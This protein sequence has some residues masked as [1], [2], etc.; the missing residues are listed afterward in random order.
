MVRAIGIFSGGL[1]SILSVRLLMDQGFKPTLLAF[2]TPFFPPDK[3]LAGA[4]ALG[5][6]LTEV[7]IYEDLLPL[8]KDPPHGLG[9]NLNPCVDCHALMFRRAGEILK[10]SG[11]PGFLFSG[12]VLGQRPMSQN[13]RALK[14]VAADSGWADY[15]L[16]P[17]S[18][19]LLPLTEAEIKGWVDRE[20]L[21][22]LNGRGRKAQLELAERYGLSAPTPAGGCLLT[23]EG[24]SRRLRWLISQSQAAGQTLWPPARLA[25]IIKRGRLFSC[26]AGRWIC[27]GRHQADNRALNEAAEAGETLCHLE[28]RP[29][30]TVLIPGPEAGQG[31]TLALA[32]ALAA[33]Y[34]DHGYEDKLTVRVEIKGG[35]SRL[36][37]V[38]NQSPA[39]LAQWMIFK[40]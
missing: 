9:R 36:C 13:P 24:Y 23:D 40:A 16:R 34:G 28:G 14:I 35:G 32:C 17:L 19:K 26:E 27:V 4:K 38:Q 37:P 29:G 8:I 3:A 30:P 2:V 5:L 31:E 25:E 20:K 39:Q 12:E 1:D 15:V 33:A 7:D 10:E 18:A 11:E 21:L 6:G 22:A